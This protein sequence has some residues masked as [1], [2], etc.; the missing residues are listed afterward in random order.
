MTIAEWFDPYNPEHIKAWRYKCEKGIWPP[1]VYEEAME[2][3]FHPSSWRAGIQA[4]IAQAW[5]DN[6]EIIIEA[7]KSSQEADKGSRVDV[8]A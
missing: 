4:K 8:R 3:Y 5:V 6:H 2:F 1:W 7:L